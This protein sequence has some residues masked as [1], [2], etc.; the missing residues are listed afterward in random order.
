MYDKVNMKLLLDF[1]KEWINPVTINMVRALLFHMQIHAK[2]GPI[3]Y[4]VRL[5]RGVPE[6]TPSSMV[7]LICT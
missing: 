4:T 1:M 6:G 5:T 2:G 7:L 3:N